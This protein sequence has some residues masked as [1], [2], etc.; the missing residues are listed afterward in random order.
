MEK[1]S[2]WLV[3][4]GTTLDIWGSRWLPRPV[5]FAPYTPKPPTGSPSK[6]CDLID[7]ARGEWK[8]AV[9][10]QN[11]LSGDADTILSIPL[12]S[13]WPD[14]KLIWHYTN[15]GRFTVKSAYQLQLSQRSAGGGSTSN[16][17]TEIW[18]LIWQLNIPPRIRVFAW[19]MCQ[20]ALPTKENLAKRIPSQL[21]NCAIC[22]DLCESEPHILLYCPLAQAVWSTS[23]FVQTLWQTRFSTMSDC[24]LVAR[25]ELSLDELGMFVAILWECWNVRN[26]FIFGSPDMDVA[27]RSSRA[28]RFVTSYRQMREPLCSSGCAAPTGWKPPSTGML[29][30][31]FDSGQIGEQGW[32]S[33][34]VVRG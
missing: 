34:F 9:I 5:T 20:G 4:K 16:P 3:G 24:I 17:Q 29:K 32:G 6:V 8:E 25:K 23:G 14:D 7:Y 27:L 19:R 28:I 26:Q 15:H 12:C 10:R 33:G 21:M 2:R 1:G 11:F 13:S 18:K 22:G 30:L 31:N